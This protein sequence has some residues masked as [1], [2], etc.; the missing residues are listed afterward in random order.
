MIQELTDKEDVDIEG[1]KLGPEH[2]TSRS[3]SIL[4]ACGI[5]SAS[6]SCICKGPNAY[7]RVVDGNLTTVLAEERLDVGLEASLD[8]VPQRL[9]LG[10][11]V[12]GAE[13]IRREVR[14]GSNSPPTVVAQ[15]EDWR[16]TPSVP[17]R[18]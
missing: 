3:R 7:V 17:L 15:G 18:C 8:L 10:R 12:L 6:P 9:R 5:I 11:S 4:R 14:R 13:V 16:R 2:A 1:F